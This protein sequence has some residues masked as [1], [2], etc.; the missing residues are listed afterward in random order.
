M[1]GEL[2]LVVGINIGNA[3]TKIALIAYGIRVNSKKEIGRGT[4]LLYNFCLINPSYPVSEILRMISLLCYLLFSV[5][6]PL[7]EKKVCHALL[8][9]GRQY[10]F[11]KTMRDFLM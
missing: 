10:G 8:P 11:I 2:L 7:F 9:T 1:I 3:I 5:I 6:K 4:S